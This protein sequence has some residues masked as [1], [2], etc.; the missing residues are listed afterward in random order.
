MDADVV[1]LNEVT[2]NFINQAMAEA[3][4]REGYYLSAVVGSPSCEHLSSVR[5]GGAFGNLL[6][7]KLPPHSLKYIDNGSGRHRHAA[8]FSFGDAHK[9]T[10][11]S[12]HLTAAPYVNEGRRKRELGSDQHEKTE[13]ERS[14][15]S[16]RMSSRGSY[17]DRISAK[18]ALDINP[19]EL[20]KFRKGLKYKKEKTD[21]CNYDDFSSV[22]PMIAFRGE[23]IQTFTF[24]NAYE[25]VKMVMKRH[26]YIRVIGILADWVIRWIVWTISLIIFPAVVFY[27]IYFI[28]GECTD[29]EHYGAHV[30]DLTDQ[31]GGQ[32]GA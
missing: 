9:V 12:T 22:G 8:Q 14:S 28:P 19:E 21:F 4:I 3:W 7:S 27:V 11:C 16:I 30:Q 10:V 15:F 25:S 29:W 26:N 5:G 24:Y 2:R 17:S 13:K 32:V 1:G 18:P 23:V 20:E 6:M 31:V